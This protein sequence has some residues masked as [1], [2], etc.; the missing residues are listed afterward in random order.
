MNPAETPVLFAQ[1]NAPVTGGLV[2]LK[3]RISLTSVFILLMA[4]A[5][6]SLHSE[7]YTFTTMAGIGGKKGDL[8]GAGGGIGFPLFNSPTGLV[9]NKA[10]NLY[11]TDSGNQLIR[12][13]TPAGAVTT[14]SGTVGQAGALDGT[15]IGASFNSPQGPAMD[16]AG[17]L[18]V[19]D[20]SSAT[21]RKIT[22]AGVVTTIAGTALSTG[23]IDGTGVAARFLKPSSVAVDSSGNLYVTDSGNHTIRKITSAGVVTT[24][25]GKAGTPGILDTATGVTALFNNPRS[26]VVDSSGTLYVAD[27]NSNTIRKIT[28]AGSVSTLAGKA[29][30]FGST[31]GV[32]S[33][34]RFNFPTSLAL[35][36]SGNL[37]VADGLNR[38]IRKVVVSTG[39]VTTL[40]GS[41][42]VVGK[43]DGT[44]TAATFSNPVGIAVDSSGN[45]YVADYTNQLIRK[46]TS[47]GV[48]TTIAGVAGMPG[49]L[50]GQGYNSTPALFSSP[51]GA[52]VDG[53]G[54]VYIADSGNNAIRKVKSSGEVSTFAGSSGSVGWAGGNGTSASFNTP[55][56]IALDP[57][58]GDFFVA[59]TVNH[60]IRKVTKTG[61]VSIFA[62]TAAVAGSADG[63]GTA[64]S[65]NLPSAV[66]VDNV[67][68]VY[69]A[70]YDNNTIRKIT[71]AGQVSTFAGA[72]G[73]QGSADGVGTTAARFNHPRGV[74]VDSGGNV[75]VADFGNHTIRKIGTDSTVLTWAGTTG[76]AGS[77]DG[78]LN[79]GRFNGPTGVAFDKSTG[80]LLVTD[81]NN[82][83]IRQV[84]VAGAI[85]TIGGVAGT[86]SNVDGAGTAARF[87]HPTGLAVDAAG[88]L[89]IAD[90]R[91]HTIRKAP[92]PTSS[93]GGSGGGTGGGSGTGGTGGSGSG[94]TGGNGGTGGS[95][96]STGTGTGFVLHPSGVAFGTGSVLFYIADTANNCIKAVSADG[97][98]TVT[99]FA[100]KNGS[101]GSTDGTGTAA[102]FNGPT[103]MVADSA[104]N[105]Y[106]CDTGNATIRKITSA[107]VVTTIAGAAGSRGTQDGTGSAALFSNPS[108]IAMNSAGNL[109]VSDST[110]STIRQITS[111]G[112]VTTF[113]GVAKAAGD[114]D[115]IGASARFN[116]PTGLAI[117]AGD[118]LY[119]ADTY[120]STIRKMNTART[121][122]SAAAV[123]T[124]TTAGNLAV[125]V[126]DAGLTGSPITVSVP[127]LVDD[128]STA[129]ATKVATALQANT[130]IAARYTASASSTVISLI[131]INNDPNITAV[132]ISLDNGTAA[133]I[134]PAPTSTFLLSGTVT[135]LAGL[136]GV[137]GIFDGAGTYALFNLPM[138]L[139]VDSAYNVYVADTGNNCIRQVSSSG[140]VT[141]LAG[142][143]GVAGNRDG[144]NTTALFNQPQ[145]L[146]L[147]SVIIVADTG[148]SVIRTVTVGNQSAVSTVALKAPTTTTPSDGG[149][150]GGGGGNIDPWFVAALL[151]L[152]GFALKAR[153]GTR[154]LQS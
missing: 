1:K 11:V 83:T 100:G 93:S 91:N 49:A 54:N 122:A 57:T 136:A 76:S 34:A 32:G 116:N 107:G 58:T 24:F 154:R 142:I 42:G 48:V 4:W 29:D 22:T 75:Y 18:Y 30:T 124:I 31:D 64:A 52:A 95:G 45:V 113:A 102:L 81:S 103:A 44:G 89:Y 153:S 56:G 151:A 9:I 84:T 55:G 63:L 27:S 40:A 152:F 12:E 66:A 150:S 147:S 132:N 140:L 86:A 120:N 119:I 35:D 92:T 73:I 110:N 7:T 149:S 38:V 104:G 60:L 117:D 8:D 21:I 72:A 67:G 39:A 105:L 77:A 41:V 43:A 5:V 47:A 145:A 16:S 36:A 131:A 14:L 78:S 28:S 71:P 88:N 139:S 59:D 134:T 125:V 74:A 53:S 96:G 82:S 69:V 112:V 61:E 98:F 50:D 3:P 10:G 85:S 68:N 106:V 51:V 26:V 70:D 127:V 79:I 2:R 97:T 114:A 17:N 94:G 15:G 135:T 6:P 87:D 33:A 129:W 121:T 109:Y 80:T 90:T 23:T 146:L 25:A 46:V 137:S 138:G 123:G 126:T 99:V 130:V 108:G 62:G 148:N 128:T 20:F 13:V 141:T 118:R 111:A 115:G 143:A 144:T 37:Y 101:A 133:G 65:F 19:A